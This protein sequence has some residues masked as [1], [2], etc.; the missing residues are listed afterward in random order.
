MKPVGGI[1]VIVLKEPKLIKAWVCGWFL[2]EFEVEGKADF[3]F[4]NVVG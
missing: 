4:D 3:I 1:Q 2:L